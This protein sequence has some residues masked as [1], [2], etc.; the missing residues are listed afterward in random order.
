MAAND[1]YGHE[2]KTVDQDEH[3]V[4]TPVSPTSDLNKPLSSMNQHAFP[5]THGYNDL[6]YAP[7]HHSQHSIDGGHRPDSYNSYSEILQK[8]PPKDP[9]PFSDNIP[10]HSTKPGGRNAHNMTLPIGER[11]RTV[12]PLRKRAWFCYI[13]TGIQIAVFCGEL[14]RNFQLQGTPISVK[15]YFN[16]MIGPSTDC[17]INIGA[18]FVPCMRSV[19]Q[20]NNTVE[21]SLF[22]C[23][24]RTT[25]DLQC[26]LGDW[27][28]FSGNN[29]PKFMGGA[30]DGTV[31]G[32]WYRFI[33]PMFYHAGIIHLAFNMFIQCTLGADMEKVIGVFRFVIVYFCSGIFGFL[34]GG[35]LGA[36]GQPS[37]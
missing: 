5:P 28:G 19:A 23:P 17:L 33:I 30:S 27:C 12:T 4:F 7:H 18:R 20:F 16:P 24:N 31:P 9:D 1:Y 14:G 25:S 29:I 6:S 35:N 10:L 32:Q 2:H 21:N 13:I 3:D 37:V 11:R 8:P 15:P 22:P 26:T 34:L 36:H